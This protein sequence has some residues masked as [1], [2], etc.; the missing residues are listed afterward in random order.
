[1]NMPKRMQAYKLRDEFNGNSLASPQYVSPE[2]MAFRSK[3][4]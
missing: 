3:L 2:E 1:M 4:G